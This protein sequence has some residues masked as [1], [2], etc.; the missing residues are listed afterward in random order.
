[1]RNGLDIT[2]RFAMTAAILGAS[3]RLD[4]ASVATITNQADVAGIP[5]ERDLIALARICL[6]VAL[7]AQ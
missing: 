6:R 5:I 4:N 1:M 7:G 2:K 3:S